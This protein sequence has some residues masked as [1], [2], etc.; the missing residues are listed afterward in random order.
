MVLYVSHTNAPG[1]GSLSSNVVLNRP[2]LASLVNGQTMIGWFAIGS[3][4]V[5]AS[6]PDGWTEIGSIRDGASD[7]TA[8]Y[9]YRKRITNKDAEPSTYTWTLSD[10]ARTNKG[11]VLL[12]SGADL[13]SPIVLGPEYIGPPGAFS[14]YFPR[15]VS[16]VGDS[17]YVAFGLMR[18]TNGTISKPSGA[19]WTSRSHQA[20]TGFTAIA[21]TGPRSTGESGTEALPNNIERKFDLSASTVPHALGFQL[22]QA[23][24]PNAPTPVSP[25]NNVVLNA[26]QV[27][28][29]DWEFSDPNP[30]DTQTFYEV[31][32]RIVG[33]L[34]WTEA[35]ASSSASFHDLAAN[36]LAVGDYEW[37][38]RVGDPM[39]TLSTWS[40]LSYFSVASP[41]NTPVITSPAVNQVI[42]E[43][44]VTMEW[45]LPVGQE[46]FQVRRV[47]D[48]NG[49]PDDTII[50]HDVSVISPDQNYYYFFLDTNRVEH[51]QVRTMVDGIWSDWA[52]VRITVNMDPPPAP[53]ITATAEPSNGLVRVV[54][55]H[56]GGIPAVDHFAV[57]R[58]LAGSGEWVRLA[59]G[60]VK[61]VDSVLVGAEYEDRT[62]ASRTEYEYR[63]VSY[64]A[65]GGFTNG[66][67][68]DPLVLNLRGT[69]IHSVLDPAGTS[70]RFLY[71]NEGG[72]DE[73]AP[74][75]ALKRYAGR[76]LPVAEFGEHEDH[77]VVA[78]LS[79]EEDEV[80]L[81]RAL[82]RLR[83]VLC[84]RD[85]SGRKLFGVVSVLPVASTFYGGTSSVRIDAV[86]YDEA[87]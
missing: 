74:E 30:G 38:V 66:A 40:S 24:A 3:D 14:G 10:T 53:L 15:V 47:A 37:Q 34:F 73:W 76:A 44:N 81:L 79:L 28:R 20:A 25:I 33:D 31:R 80:P 1:S 36:T 2:G 65:E 50:Y 64:T 75:V 77:N 60:L 63:G 83:S 59:D 86:N 19:T 55:D 71:N 70:H 41:P 48:T 58:R 45:Q 72:V 12:F 56:P 7:G 32:Y 13:L 68:S 57:E 54:L 4:R 51:L 29:L 35:S 21:V 43:D 69:W 11:G 22:E 23:K 82:A 27:N 42:T 61:I 52:S 67:A 84:Y 62:A 49:N 8:L 17:M 18:V 5:V 6:V 16:G 9:V 46:Q 85:A 78:T 87:L 39:S 26:G